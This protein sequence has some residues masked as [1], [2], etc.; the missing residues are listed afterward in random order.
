M[1][2]E[3]YGVSPSNVHTI[4]LHFGMETFYIG[5]AIRIFQFTEAAEDMFPYLLWIFFEGL[6]DA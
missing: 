3:N 4:Y 5:C 2:L 6:N 1:N